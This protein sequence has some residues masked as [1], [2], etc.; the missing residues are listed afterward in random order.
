[1]AAA[2]RWKCL[3]WAWF[4]RPRG[5]RA[6]YRLIRR[7]RPRAIVEIGLRDGRRARRMIEMAQAYAAGATVSY[8]GV[9]SFELRPAGEAPLPLKQIFRQLKCTG[10]RLRLL[11]GDPFAALARSANELTGTDLIVISRDQDPQ[12]LARAWFYI[13]RMLHPGSEVYIEQ[14]D[15]KGAISMQRMAVSEIEELAAPLVRR[16]AA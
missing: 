7:R 16:R 13:P 11:P 2:S 4:S 3:F 6:L 5:D 8:A 9:D 14:A 12:S 1:M 10:A 15:E